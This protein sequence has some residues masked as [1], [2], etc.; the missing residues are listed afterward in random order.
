MVLGGDQK[1]KE[2]IAKYGCSVMHVFDTEGDLPSFA[3]SIGIQQQS[4]APEVVVI[5][6][7]RPMAHS[8]INEYNRRTREGE[9]FKIGKYYDE[10]LGGFEVCIGAVS[11]SAYDEYFGQ[12][13]DF[14]DG[15][16]FDVIQIVY[17]TT[18]GVWPWA[19]D[20]SEW[21]IQCQP[22]LTNQ[23]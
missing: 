7:N 16:K 15:R 9:R 13:T 19:P 4:G 8:V 6:L 14:Y 21:F 11:R 20:A 2:D 22:I 5:G 23:G 18:K 12:T 3:Y 17:P 10:F 1:T